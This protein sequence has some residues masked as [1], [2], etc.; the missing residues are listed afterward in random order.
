MPEGQTQFEVEQSSSYSGTNGQPP[1]QMQEAE[2]VDS[3]QKPF[4]IEDVP[5]L[6]IQ[7]LDNQ[8]ASPYAL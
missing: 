7:H 1:G 3:E 2:Y 4:V 6:P 8:Q 5:T